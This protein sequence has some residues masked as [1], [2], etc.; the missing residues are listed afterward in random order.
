MA[1]YSAFTSPDFDANEYANAILA[2]EPY[3]PQPGANSTKPSK[4]T[5]LEPAK[6]DITVAIAKLDFGIE[7]VS[8]QIKNVVTTHHEGLL[9]Q[10]AGV[11]E[12]EESLQSVGSG[13]DDLDS[14]L[15][16]LRQKIRD[17]YQAL[18]S[19]INRLQRLHQVSDA[20]RRTSRFVVLAKRL[21]S[22]MVEL[23]DGS[24]IQGEES[25]SKPDVKVNGRSSFDAGRRSTTP[26]ME[27]EGEKERALAQAALSVAEIG[28]LLEVPPDT[29]DESSPPRISLRDIQTISAHIPFVEASRTKIAADME[30]MILNGLAETNQAMLA[31]SLQTA[32]NLRVL[33]E[34]VQNLV[35]DLSVAVESRIRSA[36]DMSKISKELLT[37]DSAPSQQQHVG[38]KSRV[39][40]EPTN[41]TAPQWTNALWN[42]LA[43]MIEDVAGACIKVYTL[44]KVLK[45]KKDPISQVL[46]L[47][48]AMKLL[49]NR[50]SFT[51][52][53]ALGRAL[54]KQTRDA[55]RNSTF[56]QQTLGNGYPRLLRLFHEF[57]AK[58]AVY[59]DTVYSVTQQS[60]ETILILRALSTFESHYLT[61]TSTR[62]TESISS[63]F[64]SSST[65]FSP[66]SRASNGTNN[67]DTAEGINVSRA[68]SN[69]LDTARFD[70]LLLRN[71]AKHVA[72]ALEMMETRADALVS[73]DRQALVLGSVGLT[74][75]GSG[76]VATREQIVNAGVGSCVW[77]VVGNVEK[78]K[79]EYPD[80][81]WAILRPSVKNLNDLFMQIVDPLLSA[82]NKELSAIISKIHRTDFAKVGD[83]MAGMGGG[84]SPYVKEITEKLTF[85]KYEILGRWNVGILSRE[86][87]IS[88]VKHVMKTFVLHVSIVKPLKESG[89]LQL[90][91]DMTEL[92]FA[93]SAF[94]TDNPQSKRGASLEIIGDEYRALRAMRP[95]LFLDND[96]LASSTRTASLP[97]LI[98]LHHILVRS[99]IELPHQLHGW[100]E[101]EYVR[102][103]EEHSEEEALTLI[104]GGLSHWEKVTESEG[105][106]LDVAKE[107][108]ELARKVLEVS[109][110]KSET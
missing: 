13:L 98:V 2:G 7:D 42:R 95:L 83:P 17:P 29:D 71:V 31:S 10:A 59:T 109:R 108:V 88:I 67:P 87:M 50:P 22:Q 5:G 74:G 9:V 99:P 32:H 85:V 19:S 45:V 52:W 48:E 15:T 57:F 41:L 72:N 65:T 4:P 70:P 36:F 61:R 12:I 38:Y 97:P 3:P 30:N 64:P 63:A 58:I 73:R 26:G 27:L 40:T 82:I 84:A 24:G 6:E 81:V 11:G 18:Q 89:K 102:W 56:M 49:E 104:D 14:S 39:R 91:S 54:E 92:E 37:K 69:E 93:L 28:D 105:G 79:E 100:Q 94:M 75:P 78:L 43:T 53:A 51:F 60:P 103:V 46:F 44:E 110:S 106:D 23:G 33:P 16:K 107:Y 1:D 80:G 47:D 101:S 68:I 35:D 20:L 55:S 25:G 21:Q 96:S 76:A 8:K 34:I 62:L 90:T 86:W 66:T 77:T